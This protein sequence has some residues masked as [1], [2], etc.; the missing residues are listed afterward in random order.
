M[1]V[2]LE[3]LVGRSLTLDLTAQHVTTARTLAAPVRTALGCD[4]ADP[5]VERR[6]T[7]VTGEGVAVSLNHVTIVATDRELTQ[8]L[9]DEHLPIGHS[10][11]AGRRH[12][13]RTVLGAGLTRWATADD[14][15]GPPCVYKESVLIDHRSVAVVHLH[16]RFNPAVVPLGVP[17]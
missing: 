10:L 9:T 6:S 8:L 5:V 16:E 11:A 2:L 3:A 17:R 4:D 15:P 14:E 1:T 7:L 13:A 12:L